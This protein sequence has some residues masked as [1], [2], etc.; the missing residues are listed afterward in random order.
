MINVLLMRCH[1]FSV[2]A[3]LHFTHSVWYCRPNVGVWERFHTYCISPFAEIWE[4]T[5]KTLRFIGDGNIC[6]NIQNASHFSR[7]TARSFVSVC[8]LAHTL[9]AHMYK[10]EKKKTHIA[11]QN[12]RHSFKS[13]HFLQSSRFR[14]ESLQSNHS[15]VHLDPDRGHLTQTLSDPLFCSAPTCVYYVPPA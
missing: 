6:P 5:R 9:A 14:V 15:R 1:K 12:T 11:T 4:K 13:T 3:V 2:L 8:I 10:K 7:S